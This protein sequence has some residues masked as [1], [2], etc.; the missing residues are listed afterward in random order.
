[1]NDIEFLGL[2]LEDFACFA[3]KHKIN[4]QTTEKENIIVIMGSN[5][6]GKTSLYNGFWWVLH[7]H[8]LAEKNTHQD[9]SKQKV[10]YYRHENDIKDTYS[11][12]LKIKFEGK[13]YD[14]R[15][16]YTHSMREITLSIIESGEEIKDKKEL[17]TEI[18]ETLEKVDIETY[19]LPPRPKYRGKGEQVL[20]WLT[21]YITKRKQAGKAPIF[22]DDRT[23]TMDKKPTK[24]IAKKLGTIPNQTILLTSPQELPKLTPSKEFKKSI[25]KKYNLE[26]KQVENRRWHTKITT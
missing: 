4:L 7:G 13:T 25:N 5:G 12:T 15:R 10:E 2:E 6:S 8:K 19:E 23:P 11:V 18:K 20:Q 22:L 17:F 21:K 3:G 1:M 16:T 24:E 9:G 14:I 26:T